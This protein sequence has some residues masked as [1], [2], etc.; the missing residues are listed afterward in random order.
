MQAML[1][2]YY[3]IKTTSYKKLRYM[4][5]PNTCV[6]K[7]VQKHACMVFSWPVDQYSNTN[8]ILCLQI[9]YSL[10][11]VEFDGI[12]FCLHLNSAA[13]VIIWQNG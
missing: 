10:I 3:T 11:L 9:C 13:S 2:V 1:L 8:V 4:Y 12:Q 6:Q 5:M 7:C